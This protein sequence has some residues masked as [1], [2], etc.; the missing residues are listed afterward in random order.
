MNEPFAFSWGKGTGTYGHSI[1][2]SPDRALLMH[3]H[4]IKD[5]DLVLDLHCP[6][7][8]PMMMETGYMFAIQHSSRKP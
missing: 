6:P 4:L 5:E 1:I 2:Y 7:D 3:R 8:C